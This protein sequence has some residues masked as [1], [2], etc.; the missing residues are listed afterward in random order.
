MVVEQNR[1]RVDDLRKDGLSAVYGDAESPDVQRQAH[2]PEA[3]LLVIAVPDTVGVRQMIDTA[4]TLNPGIAVVARTHNAEEAALFEH[5]G[6]ATVFLG[7]RE[8]A[9][10]MVADIQRRLT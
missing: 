4:K 1:E 5:E 7:E 6:L 9:R 2:V 10:N 8:L 3:A